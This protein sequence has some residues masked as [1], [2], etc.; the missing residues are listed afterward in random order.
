LQGLPL[1]EAIQFKRQQQNTF[2]LSNSAQTF[3]QKS[4]QYRRWT[5]VKTASWL[6]IP[7]LIIGGVTEYNLREASISRDTV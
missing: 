6:I 1:T 2:P 4:M 5:R 3:I 7:A